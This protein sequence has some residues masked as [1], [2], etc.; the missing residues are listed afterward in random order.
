[1]STSYFL[2]AA[3]AG[4]SVGSRNGKTF[5]TTTLLGAPIPAPAKSAIFLCSKPDGT[6]DVFVD[7]TLTLTMTEVGGKGSSATFS[8]DYSNGCSGKITPVG[9]VNLCA[10]ADSF[11]GFM[12]KTVDIEVVCADK[13]GGS[14][15][16]SD[17]YICI[18]PF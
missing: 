3:Q 13:C 18:M 8:Y 15:G 16:S 2:S 5:Y 17:I 12:G 7:D 6:G 1:M 4:R 9:P 11:S 14:M 10:E